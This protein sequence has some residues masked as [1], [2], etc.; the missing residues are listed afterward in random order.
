[1]HLLLL[2]VVNGQKGGGN[3]YSNTVCTCVCFRYMYYVSAVCTCTCTCSCVCFQTLCEYTHFI[4][5]IHAPI[6]V[7][8]VSDSPPSPVHYWNMDAK[9]TEE[10]K[11]RLSS[12][13]Q[14]SDK[15]MDGCIAVLKKQFPD[16][17]A[18]QST[19]L[20]SK[21][22]RLKPAEENSIFFHNF[23]HHWVVSQLKDDVVYV[24]DSLLPKH[25]H[26]DLQQQL[27]SLYGNRAVQIPLVQVQK[28]SSDCGCFAI[29]FTISLM[30]GDDPAAEVYDQKEMR[31][32]LI[33]CFEYNYFTLFPSKPKKAKRIA[34][35]ITITLQ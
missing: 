20:T 12:G 7:V 11:E 29:A 17:P 16:M 2:Q 10:D 32:H 24:Y 31:Q 3:P 25:L 30:Y 35:P 27:V 4:S 15:H 33:K 21:P 1:M 26:P 14:L 13:A 8:T 22:Q 23:N 6:D 28:G 18:P 19:L 9:L 34:P 5:P